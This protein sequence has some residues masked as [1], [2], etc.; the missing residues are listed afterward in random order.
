MTTLLLA[1]V[2]V[3]ALIAVHDALRAPL[4]RRLALRNVLRRRGEG[5]LVLIGCLLGATIITS[6]ILVGDSLRASVRDVAR[7]ELGPV[8]ELVR[9]PTGRVGG[10]SRLVAARL[11]EGAS[12][13]TALR[14]PAV[15]VTVG[16]TRRAEPHLRLL[17]LD[18]A[19][20]RDFGGSAAGT[21]LAGVEAPAPG[22][23][24]LEEDAARGLGVGPGDRIRVI[25]AGGPAP[26]G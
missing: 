5:A 1:L 10:A 23:V 3:P 7:S 22:Q 11:P 6:S 4:I 17:E 15:G 19:R 18:V 16:G 2:A 20:A 24:V 25:A 8:D 12:V 13:T 21:G 26:C 9:V 14:A